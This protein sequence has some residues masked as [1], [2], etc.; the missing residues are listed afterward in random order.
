MQ[1]VGP[2]LWREG[3]LRSWKDSDFSGTTYLRLSIP[4]AWLPEVN[5]SGE[6]DEELQS[7]PILEL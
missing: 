6:V 3:L 1:Y 7:P 5:G 2:E 4:R